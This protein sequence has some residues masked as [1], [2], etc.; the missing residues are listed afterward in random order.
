[1]SPW[2]YNKIC[3]SCKNFDLRAPLPHILC[4]HGACQ[5]ALLY[6]AIQ[7]QRLCNKENCGFAKVNH[8][9]SLKWR[10][11]Q[12]KIRL[13]GQC[14]EIFFSGFFHGSASPQPQSI[15]LGPFQIFPKIRG[16]ICKTR[17]TIGIN[18]T[19]GKFST[20][21]N[22][23]GGNIATVINDTGSKFSVCWYLWQNMETISG[24]RLLKVNLKAKVYIY[25]NST[26]QMCPN[27]IIKIF[28]LKIF[29]ICHW[30]HRHRWRI[31]SR[32]YLRKFSNKFVMGVMVYSGAW[33]KLIHVKTR[34]RKSRGTVPLRSN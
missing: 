1:M 3:E 15:P 13:K 22:D 33:W 9:P 16:D 8:Q 26:T 6:R 23:T 4:C 27:K 21:V 12:Q 2:F 18:Y 19:G 17:C 11:N 25:V 14:H 34:S 10:K 24:C 31:L 30:C 28:W 5:L 7:C 20:G 29:S 32:E